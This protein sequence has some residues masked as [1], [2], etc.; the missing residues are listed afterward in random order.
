MS[1]NRFGH[2]GHLCSGHFGS[3]LYG[4]R[5]HHFRTLFPGA[6]LLTMSLGLWVMVNPLCEWDENRVGELEPRHALVGASKMV[7]S[8][9]TLSPDSEIS[10][11]KNPLKKEYFFN[12]FLC[13]LRAIPWQGLIS[14]P[15][16]PP[17]WHAETIPHDH[18]LRCCNN[19]LL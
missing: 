15:I 19:E 16:A 12:G 9:L 17:P 5:H 13:L 14:R 11:W 4:F 8:G 6:N 18:A 10:K 1:E 3:R 7:D 2:Y